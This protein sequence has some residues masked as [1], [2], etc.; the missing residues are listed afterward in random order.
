MEILPNRLRKSHIK[1]AL[2]SLKCLNSI[3]DD[4]FFIEFVG[5][6]SIRSHDVVGRAH[7][8]IRKD[9]HDSQQRFILLVGVNHMIGV[10]GGGKC[11]WQ[12][13]LNNW[14]AEFNREEMKKKIIKS[15]R[16]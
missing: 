4:A 11:G 6:L 10:K 15:P 14:K 13:L 1:A 16:N 3:L 2:C 8:A 7:S 9:P 5:T 12:T